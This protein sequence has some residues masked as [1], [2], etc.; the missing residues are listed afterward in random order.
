[1]E[2]LQNKSMHVDTQLTTYQASKTTLSHCLFRHCLGPTKVDAWG[3]HFKDVLLD[4]L[5]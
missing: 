3:V 1:M 2:M 5:I 4:S